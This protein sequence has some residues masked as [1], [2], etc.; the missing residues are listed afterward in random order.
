MSSVIRRQRFKTLVVSAFVF[1]VLIYVVSQYHYQIRN[2]ISYGT[3][4]MWDQADGPKH[5]I[6][7]YHADGVVVDE[8]TCKLHGWKPRPNVLDYK[9]LDAF[10]VGSELDLLELRLNELAPIVDRFFIIESN[11]TSTGLP[12]ETHFANNRERFAQFN[13]KISYRLW[14]LIAFYDS[15]TEV[16][17]H[18][19]TRLHVTG[20]RTLGCRL[21]DAQRHDRFSTLSYDRVPPE[22]KV[23]G[24]H[25]RH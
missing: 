4:P 12:K 23:S 21:Q 9:L 13:K 6:P 18:Q 7:H 22:H 16:S 20:W 10:L 14:V 3:R 2:I 8:H 11:V 17:L 19:C 15:T 5:V 25:V 24:Y 1:G